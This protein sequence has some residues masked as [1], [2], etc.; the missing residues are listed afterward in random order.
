MEGVH[1]QCQNSARGLWSSPW[2]ELQHLGTSPSSASFTGADESKQ[3]LVQVPKTGMSLPNALVVTHG[4][5][6]DP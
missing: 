1:W 5:A 3:H 4:A 2:I 6:P